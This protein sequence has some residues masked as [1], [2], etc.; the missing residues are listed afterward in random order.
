MY[1]FCRQVHYPTLNL[2]VGGV[3]AV[4]ADLMRAAAAAVAAGVLPGYFWAAVLAPRAGLAERLTWSS[5]LSVASVPAVALALAKAAD[6]GVTLW[7]AIGAVALVAGSG[8]LAF[9]ARGPAGPAL[10]RPAPVRSPGVLALALTAFA[11]ALITVVAALLHQRVP[12]LLLALVAVMVAVAGALA[13]WTAGLSPAGPPAHDGGPTPG[14]ST[15]PGPGEPGPGEPGPRPTPTSK[16]ALATK[17]ALAEKSVPSATE[18]QRRPA[19]RVPALGITLALITVRGYAG[20][21]TLNWPYIR[22][23]DQFSYVIMSEQM[24]RHGSYGTFL[25][26]PP[27]FSTLSA[28]ICRI[29]GL[30]PYTLYPVL[31]PALLLLTSL[32][33]Y[34]LATRLWGWEYGI[35][36][37]A[38]SG[39]VLDGAYTSFFEGRYPDLTAAFFLMVML[40]AALVVLYQSPSLRSGALVTV[41]GASVVL[42]HPVV[43]MYLALLLALVAIIGLPYLLLRGLR[44][45]AR[46]LLLTLAAAAALSACYAAYTYDLPG[47]ISGSSSTSHSV[48]IV[49]G[50]QPVP[51]ASHLLTELGPALVWLSLFGFAALAA[52][53]RYLRTPPQVLTALTV[54]GW[55]AVMYA[56]SRTA[57]DG[58]PTRFERDLGAPL[59]VMAAFGA[60]LL[61]RSLPQAWLARKTSA[62][63]LAAVGAAVVGAMLVV[64][65]VANVVTDSR[66]RGNILSPPVAAAARWLRE[67]NTGGTIITTPWMK[68]VSNRAVLAMG[69]YTGLQSY[70]VA[71][72]EHPRSL[73]P[74]GRQPLIDSHEVLWKPASCQSARALSRNDVRYVV[75]Y[76]FGHS[77]NLPAFQADPARYHR[78]YQNSAVIIYSAAQIPC[79]G[80]ADGTNLNPGPIRTSPDSGSY[81]AAV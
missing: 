67:H 39:L 73:P 30:A 62:T 37:A 61:L 41:V 11:A 66:T 3:V 33:A 35:A 7:V 78:V 55:C 43:S 4:F 34:A 42:Y 25:V 54:L 56:G 68:P 59:S 20:V 49:L 15:A 38:L 79:Q 24:L 27:G 50:T 31:A 44:R 21:I 36:A 32:A 70:T 75:L 13:T 74:A 72:I 71:K 81:K 48:A 8:A 10:P 22:G 57:A 52:A 9:A 40:G 77:A 51:G 46:V 29:S 26:Y 53:V 16:P 65:S 2:G 6:T 64:P 76:R 23:T 18:G 5:V 28:V 63:V 47:I 60:G 58:F 45:E 1:P 19:W 12:G 17:T 80:Q 69:G 14:G